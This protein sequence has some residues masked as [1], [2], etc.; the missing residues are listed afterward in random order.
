MP[1]QLPTE[2]RDLTPAARLVYLA[3]EGSVHDQDGLVD[4]TGLTTRRIREVASTLEEI[5]VIATY[6]H[7]SDARRRIY[8]DPD[9]FDAI[10]AHQRYL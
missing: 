5:D 7:P 4:R 1:E 10:E 9:A 3:L 6:R 2:V 8:Y